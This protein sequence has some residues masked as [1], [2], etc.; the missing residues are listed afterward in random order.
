MSI[1]KDK[2]F[3]ISISAV[4]IF[5]LLWTFDEDIE[6]SDDILGIVYDVNESKNGF[7]F[8]FDLTNGKTQKCFFIEEPV[9]FGMYFVSGNFSDDGNI[10][11][12]EKM[13]SM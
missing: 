9:E 4:L 7:V 13:K 11:F 5:T 6:K 12:I 1:F 2:Y 8:N 3:I 10:F